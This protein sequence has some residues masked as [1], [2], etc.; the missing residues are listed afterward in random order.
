MHYCCFPIC[1]DGFFF[2]LKEIQVGDGKTTI[3]V[4]FN[5]RLVCFVITTFLC[6]LEDS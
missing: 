2:G 6:V 4:S 5:V 3:S 1:D